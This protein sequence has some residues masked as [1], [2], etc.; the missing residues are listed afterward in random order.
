VSKSESLPDISKLGGDKKVKVEAQGVVSLKGDKGGDFSD[1]SFKEGN[2]NVVKIQDL[3]VQEKGKDA[4]KKA[5]EH[6]GHAK[7]R[8]GAKGKKKAASKAKA[9][10]TKK[11]AE[12]AGE[13]G[14]TVQKLIKY[15]PS[16]S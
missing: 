1:F 13:V 12:A 10:A 7:V 14:K 9:K 4:L 15:T 2:T 8:G 16:K 11:G 3:V 6:E 5:Q